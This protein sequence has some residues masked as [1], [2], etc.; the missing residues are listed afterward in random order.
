MTPTRSW[1][2]VGRAQIRAFSF[3]NLY[4]RVGFLGPCCKKSGASEDFEV[5]LRASTSSLIAAPQCLDT[6]RV[7]GPR[8]RVVAPAN[9]ASY[10]VPLPCKCSLNL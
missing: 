1:W 6:R 5:C 3:F 7:D 9:V 8:S 10:L 2:S 4:T